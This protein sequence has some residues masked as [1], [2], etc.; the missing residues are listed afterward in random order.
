MTEEKQSESITEF[1]RYLRIAGGVAD[2]SERLKVSPSWCYNV[3]AGRR[4][5]TPEMAN[6]IRDDASPAYVNRCLLV[7]GEESCQ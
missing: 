6:R 3:L 7:F 5:I 2:A 4:A 1:K